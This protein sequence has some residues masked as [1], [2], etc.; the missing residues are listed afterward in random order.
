MAKEFR[1][2]KLAV[3]ALEIVASIIFLW[4]AFGVLNGSAYL[5]NGWLGGSAN[6]WLPL[7]Y[8]GAVLGSIMLL[9]SSFSNLITFEKIGT[10][11]GA[12]ISMLTTVFTAFALLAL[13]YGNSTYFW[14]TI[15]AF[16]LAFIG[17]GFQTAE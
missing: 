17:S 10:S 15:I 3:F 5:Y 1:A 13:T 11:L 6:V 9:I 16:V 4:L 12:R 2:N 7:L 8:I 14:S